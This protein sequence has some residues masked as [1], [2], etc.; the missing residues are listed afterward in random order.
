SMSVKPACRRRSAGRKWIDG[1]IKRISINDNCLHGEQWR[2]QLDSKGD[3]VSRLGFGGRQRRLLG[4]ETVLE[5]FRRAAGRGGRTA[6]G[7]GG[8]HGGGSP[9]GLFPRIA[10][11]RRRGCRAAS[12]EPVQPGRG[13]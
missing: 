5:L 4:I 12:L 7:P 6:G 11:H 3:D 8:S 10:R 2:R 1:G 9:D 13:G